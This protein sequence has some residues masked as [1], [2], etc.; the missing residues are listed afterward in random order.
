M[1]Q[2]ISG[3]IV[4]A[5]RVTGIAC[6]V[7][8]AGISLVAFKTEKMY[9]DVFSKLGITKDQANERIISGLLGGYLNYYGMRNLK[10]IAL[11]DRTAV[12]KDIAVYAKQYAA[13][14]AFKKEY[15]RMKERDKPKEIAKPE[16]PEEMRASMIK[17]AKEAVTSTEGYLK[18]AD[19]SLKP[20]FE[21]SFEDAKLNLKQAEDP[22]NKYQK[23]YTQNYPTLVKD[24][25]RSNEQNLKTWEA[26]YPENHLLYVKKYLQIF[27]DATKDVDFAA[28]LT[29]RNGKKFFVKKE[30]ESKGNQWKA[31]FRTGKDAVEAARAF[32]QQWMTEIQ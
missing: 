24:F 19:A 14:D 25:A 29:E 23:N 28:E 1:N 18:K 6:L 17:N 30:Y 22:N 5:F 32:A 9:A 16:T 4:K 31:A 3:K 20:V 26:K 2:G 11:N 21:K 13:T 8:V 15:L 7:F 10:N 27:L 12:I